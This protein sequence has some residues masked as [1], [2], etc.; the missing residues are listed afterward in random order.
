MKDVKSAADLHAVRSDEDIHPPAPSDWGVFVGVLLVLNL[1]RAPLTMSGIQN[2]PTQ[3]KILWLYAFKSLLTVSTFLQ[4]SHV[5]WCPNGV[6]WFQTG[7]LPPRL[8]LLLFFRSEWALLSSRDTDDGE[9]TPASQP[10]MAG[11]FS[12]RNWGTT[13]LNNNSSS[14]VRWVSFNENYSHY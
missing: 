14:S 7:F 12:I 5:M 6:L 2:K 8:R 1:F 3:L 13:P 10:N 4:T 9:N 11:T